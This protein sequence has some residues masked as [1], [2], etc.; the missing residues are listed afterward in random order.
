[1][2]GGTAVS[3][4]EGF[5]ERVGLRVCAMGW[6]RRPYQ[7]EPRPPDLSHEEY[8]FNPSYRC[9]RCGVVGHLDGHG[10]LDPTPVYRPGT[11]AEMLED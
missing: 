9:T 4:I 8:R 5:V 2:N 7:K 11:A 10:N 1:M 6:H 3:I